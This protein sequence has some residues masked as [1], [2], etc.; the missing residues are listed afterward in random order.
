MEQA[1]V[2]WDVAFSP[3]GQWLVT[4]LGQGVEH[5]P[6]YEGQLW[7]TASGTLVARMPHARQVLAVAFSH[8]GKRI[9]TGSYDQAKIW[10]FQSSTGD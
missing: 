3:D 10:E 6:A 8:D 2:V 7:E 5:P 1:D 9:A 4:G